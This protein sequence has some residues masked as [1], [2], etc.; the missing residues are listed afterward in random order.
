MELRDIYELI[1]KSIVNRSDERPL[2]YLFTWLNL[3][4]I[5]SLLTP[6]KSW[7]KILDVGGSESRLAKTLAELGFDVTV[8]DI[9]DVEH[10][11]A[12]F[13]RENILEFEFPE[14]EFD[15]IVAISTI[16]HIGLPAY[17]QKLIDSDGDVKTMHK[18]YRWL[19]SGGVA[20]VTLPYGK[21][22]H[23]PQF[24]RVYDE[25]TLKERIIKDKW[26]VVSILYACKDG[27]WD[28]CSE[29]KARD[30]DACVF[31]VLQKPIKKGSR[32]I[33]FKLHMCAL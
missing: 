12:K 2:E 5:T 30:R 6:I 3:T 9:N 15:I 28:I 25:K 26:N 16:E 20:I 10:G 19:K 23:P 18:I 33:M 13:V 31:L 29:L 4:M 22:H 11:D 14:E 7:I 1:E 17:G 24:E 27:R 21:P 32:K 8:I